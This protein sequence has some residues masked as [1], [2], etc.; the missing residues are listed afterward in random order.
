MSVIR[1][2]VNHPG[3]HYSGW[4]AH[5]FVNSQNGVAP[6]FPRFLREGGPQLQGYNLGVRAKPVR[7]QQQ[8]CLHFI[9]FSC[10]QRTK[11]LDSA[12]ARETFEQELERVRRWYGC[13]VTGYVVMPE[14]VHLLVSE[15]QRCKLS[16]LI[17]MLKQITSRKL[18]PADK[19]RLWQVRYYDFRCGA[20]PNG[21]RSC[22]TFI[23]ILCIADW[24]STR[25]IGGGAASHITRPV[26][27]A[28]WRS[29]RIGWRV[30]E[31]GWRAH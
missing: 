8:R 6:P 28:Q 7:Y 27:K 13:F 25:R 17:Q 10:Y 11:L 24:C 21:S 23:V 12:V 16:V 4:L 1:F 19:R 9:T 14:H 2:L 5:S 31:N 30:T 22:A 18:K 15:P 3:Q 26:W 29:S 20:A